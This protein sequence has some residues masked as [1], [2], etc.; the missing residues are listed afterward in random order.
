MN[1]EL[2]DKADDILFEWENDISS[3]AGHNHRS[4]IRDELINLILDDVK[5]VINSQADYVS[6]ENGGYINYSD[7]IEAIDNLRGSNEK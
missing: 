7:C 1:K 6:S 3:G 2:R 4:A 5:D